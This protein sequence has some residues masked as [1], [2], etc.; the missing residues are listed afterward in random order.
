MGNQVAFFLAPACV[1]HRRYTKPMIQTAN[2]RVLEDAVFVPAWWLQGAAA[3]SLHPQ[4]KSKAGTWC[5][6]V[7]D[8]SEVYNEHNI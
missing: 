6:D 1:Q 4:Q 3:E 2:L 5:H 8:P 7:R